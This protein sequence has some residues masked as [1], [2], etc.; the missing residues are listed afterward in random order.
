MNCSLLV[1]GAAAAALVLA[2]CSA[3]RYSGHP[4]MESGGSEAMLP[5]EYGAS[6]GTGNGGSIFYADSGTPEIDVS[7]YPEK[8]K[9]NYRLFLEICSSCHTPAR[10]IYSRRTMRGSWAYYVER[11]R[12]QGQFEPKA[13][14]TVREAERIVDFLA[15]DSEIRKVRDREEFEKRLHDLRRRFM[16]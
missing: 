9:E 15:H 4:G 10:A 16:P 8:Q 13:R 7:A 12:I 5:K 11:M 14:F 1:K 3:V 2:G 6:G